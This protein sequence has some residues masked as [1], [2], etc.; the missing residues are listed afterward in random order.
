MILHLRV[1]TYI[2]Q[3]VRYIYRDII[4]VGMSEMYGVVYVWTYYYYNM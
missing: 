2:T 4:Y 1:D 3:V